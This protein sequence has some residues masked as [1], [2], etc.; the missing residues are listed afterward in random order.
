MQQVLQDLEKGNTV[1]TEVPCP[2]CRPGHLLVQTTVSLI[3]TGTERMLL[4]FGRANLLN[5]ARQQPDKVR[6]VFDKISTDGLQTTIDA[7][8]S[9]LKQPLTMGYSNVG[10]VLEVGQGVQGYSVGDRVVSNGPHAD[11]VCVPKNLCAKIPDTVPDE[12]AAFTV[13]GSI[14]LQGIRLLQPQLGDCVVVIG[15]GLI[16]Q[17]SIQLLIAQ[18]CRVLGIDLDADKLALAR[19]LGATVCNPSAGEDPLDAAAAFSRGR[20]V[21]GVLIAASSKSSDPVSQAAKMS[22]QRGKIVMVGATGLTLSRGDFYQKELT[23]QVSCSYGPGRNDSSYEL[24]GQDYPIGFVRWTEQRN[25]EAVL[26]MLAEGKIVVA[27]LIS[28]RFKI[29]DAASAYDRLSEDLKLMALLLEY[30][31]RATSTDRFVELGSVSTARIVATSPVVGCIGSGNYA[32]RILLPAFAQTGVRLKTIV[33]SGGVSAAV[34]GKSLGFEN[35]ATDAAAVMN[36]DD[37]DT[38]IIATRHDTHAQFVVEALD[39]GKNVFVEKPLALNLPDL[40]RID[41]SYRR[42]ASKGSEPRLMVGFNRRFS[43][44]V[45]K[46][47]RLLRSSPGPMA[48]VYTC[49]AGMIPANHWTQDPRIGGGRIVGEACHFVDLVRFLVAQPI[50]AVESVGMGAGDKGVDTGDVATITVKF[51]DGSIASIHYFANGHA[52]FPKERIEV[53]QGGRVLCLN[54]FRSLTGHGVPGFRSVKSWKQNKGQ[55]E[56]ASSFVDALRRGDSSPIALTELMEVSK[57]T[58][59]AASR[60]R[61]ETIDKDSAQ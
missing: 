19:T 13:V 40:Q 38:V 4:D 20:G 22:R 30:S 52:K 56:C 17:M 3:S 47:E 34:S 58:I 23:F 25:F 59:D 21:D 16:G 61:N 8:K 31:V 10:V 53:F 14:A 36:D 57:V 7:V 42:A 41:E 44:L 15:L 50:V 26:D 28:D 43:P 18:G 27:S 46:L 54:N 5:K 32:A 33:S 29:S 12:M 11:V 39:N 49:N 37:I 9:K 2:M 51:D 48:V 24:K 35:S 55:Q 45:V 6:A 60:L 1:V